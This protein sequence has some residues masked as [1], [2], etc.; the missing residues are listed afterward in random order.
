MIQ[1][2]LLKKICQFYSKNLSWYTKL[3]IIIINK[4]KTL[5]YN[6]ELKKELIKIIV[7]TPDARNFLFDSLF[8]FIN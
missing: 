1:S 6:A 5:S 2:N 8:F 4:P 7:S 3:N